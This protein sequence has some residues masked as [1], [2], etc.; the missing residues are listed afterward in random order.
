MAEYR[1]FPEDEKERL[2][3]E[4]LQEFGLDVRLVRRD[5][6]LV[7]E[8]PVSG[9]HQ[10]QHQN[11]TG[12]LSFKQLKFHCF[13]CGTSGSILW[14]IGEL[15]HCSVVE[16]RKW[17][18][19]QMGTGGHVMELADLLRYL[20]ALYADGRTKE[21]IPIYSSR[22]LD[23]WRWIHPYMTEI[24]HVPQKNLEHFQIGYAQHYRVG[25]GQTSERIVLPHF[26]NGQ[27]VGWQTRRLVDDGSP[28][29]L[30][31][32]GF[33]KDQTIYNYEASADEV[34][35]VESMMS[36]I[37]HAH[38]VHMEATFGASVTD[39]QLALLAK[40]KKIVL[41]MD[42]DQAGWNATEGVWNNGKKGRKQQRSGMIDYLS[43]YCDVW[44]VDNPYAADSGDMELEDVVRLV[45]EA[46]PFPL[47]RPPKTLLCYK[48]GKINEEHH[49]CG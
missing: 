15:K 31:S 21:P 24:R 10:D 23:P 4:L 16:A 26:W 38:E 32:T 30:S 49:P 36:V 37:K 27:L 48:C 14:F 33:P 1:A 39:G 42:N 28:K 46:V 7:F 2:C 45:A 12:G 9:Y 17:L 3:R 25:A 47:W 6:W 8:C 20:D 44:V 11:P 34:V 5:E 18:Q 22:T 13:G 29:Y 43:R 41:W 40:H 19:T 35:I